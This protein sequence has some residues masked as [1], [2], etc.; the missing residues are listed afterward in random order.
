MLEGSATSGSL[1]SH[2]NSSGQQPASGTDRW[3][4]KPLHHLEKARLIGLHVSRLTSESSWN[5]RRNQAEFI[6]SAGLTGGSSCPAGAVGTASSSW[7]FSSGCR[8]RQD[9]SGRAYGDKDGTAEWPS[10]MID[11]P[12]VPEH[13]P[14]GIVAGGTLETR[15]W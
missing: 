10:F 8:P 9:P 5:V 3:K 15:S 13:R 1:E 12:I 11:S 14:S 2:P 7:P 4:G 6:G